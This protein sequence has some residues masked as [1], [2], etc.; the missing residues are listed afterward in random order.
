MLFKRLRPS[1]N[2]LLEKGTD[3]SFQGRFIDTLSY[4]HFTTE[5]FAKLKQIDELIA[6]YKQEMV[7]LFYEGLK[8]V[9]PEAA[10][11]VTEARI[12]AY[13]N[14]FLRWNATARTS[15]NRFAFPF[16]AQTKSECR[17]IDRCL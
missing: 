9:K 2:E 3:Y 10:N 4:N 6:P 14:A 7:R 5:D 8:Q 17:K 1:L 12:E 15:M 16:V 11:A 13:M